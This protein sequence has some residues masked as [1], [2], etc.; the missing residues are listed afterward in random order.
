M[1][2]WKLVTSHYLNCGDTNW[3]YKEVDRN[4][5]KEKRKT[6]PVPRF[7]DI[8]DPSD[9]TN[10]WG[11]RDNAT[12][13]II[14][15]YAGKG[16]PKDIVFEGDPTPDMMPVDDEAKEISASF[17]DQWAYKPDTA[18]ISYSQSMIERFQAEKA[19]AESK[20]QQVEIAGLNDLVAVMAQS[21]AQ[22]QQLMEALTHGKGAP[23]L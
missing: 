13:E 12:G 5:G 8:N 6:L 9:W 14:V 22:N 17:A 21:L 19:E 20:P 4:T 16:D 1:A 10:S 11:N 15:C 2:R 18:E 7:L 3:E 23:R